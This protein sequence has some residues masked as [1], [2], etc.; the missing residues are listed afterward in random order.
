MALLEGDGGCLGG[1]ARKN[2]EPA[3]GELPPLS[4]QP[5]SSSSG[6]FRTE[7]FGIYPSYASIFADNGAYAALRALRKGKEMMSVPP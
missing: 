2:L 4:R 6:H 1:A 7:S 5:F 3:G